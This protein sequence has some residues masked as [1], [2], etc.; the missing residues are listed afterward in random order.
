MKVLIVDGSKQQRL[1]LV[2]ALGELTNVVIQG[3]VADVRSAL[4]A[5]A[6]AR[7]DVVVTGV[8]LRDGEGTQL[9]ERVRELAVVPSIVVV[10][11]SEE[12]R[13]RYLAAGADRYVVDASD[14]DELKAAVA[15][16]RMRPRGSVPPADSYR[17]LG[18]MTAGVVHDFNNYLAV[19]DSSL[20]LMLRRPDDAPEL[21][22]HVRAVMDAMSRL[23]ASLLSYAR[24]GAPMPERLDLATVV[25]EA[26][27]IVRRMIPI[28]VHL[29]L[30]LA[31]GLRPIMG[32][33]SQLEQL[34]L[35]LVI[36]ACDAMRGGGEL[37]V[38]VR[39]ATPATVLFEVSDSGIGG[40]SLPLAGAPSTSARGA[41]LGLAIVQ[42]VVDHHRGAL[43]VTPRATGGTLVAV[44]LPATA[45]PS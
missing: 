11:G 24:G 37:H 30:E 16:L 32:V 19:L 38:A 1:D 3:A 25:S 9:V 14:H 29:T 39:G 23:N 2:E 22:P 21:W 27:T 5:V 18:R 40:L 17:L 12:Q 43:R 45:M 31:D 4:Q 13:A 42:Q 15:T 33:R 10:A 44:M 35:N 36:N 34:V 20:E 28:D 7:P 8:V 26:M 6:D 41:G